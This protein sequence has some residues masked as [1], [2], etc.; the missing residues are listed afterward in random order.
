M[1]SN[2]ARR[3]RPIG[4]SPLGMHNPRRTNVTFVLESELLD[5]LNSQPNKSR[6]V[7]DAVT[8]LRELM[9]SDFS[10]WLKSQPDQVQVVR[11]AIS[12]FKDLNAG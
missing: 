9:E 7:R 10:E 3:G 2:E 12:I 11:D 4:Y 6:T 5:W 8:I 1:I